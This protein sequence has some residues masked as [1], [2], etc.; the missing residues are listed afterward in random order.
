MGLTMASIKRRDNGKWRARY[1]DH[2]GKEHARHFDKRIDAETWLDAVKSS[3]ITGTYVD[4]R[5]GKVTLQSWFDQWSATKVWAKT[6]MTQAEYAV[7]S[8]PFLNKELRRITHA[9]VQGWVKSQTVP[10]ETRAAGLSPATIETRHKFVSMCFAAA[11]KE[12][13]ISHNPAEGVQLP[14]KRRR[15]A[16]MTVPTPGEVRALLEASDDY[17]R[18]FISVA[19]F[20]GLRLGEVAGL[21][22]G[23]VD[24]LRKTITV[25][26]QVQGESNTDQ[27][28]VPPKDGSERVVFVPEALTVIL[29]QHLSNFGAWHDKDGNQ[30]MFTNGGGLF[31]RKSAAQRFRTIRRRA[32]L[33]EFTLHDL[34]HFFASGLISQGCDVVTVQRALG[35][36]APSVT[37][38][39]YSHLWPSAEDKTRAAAGT[40]MGEVLETAADS[41]R[42]REV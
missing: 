30:W 14:R 33:E 16:A 6:T 5:A 40:I 28:V 17:F 19:A 3:F 32:G 26:R 25:E 7:K 20:A 18:S 2:D 29:S 24:C 8:T 35:H 34:R 1:R 15:A 42:T 12:R 36:S 22:V 41:W 27:Y 4:P 9:E 13:L 39:V 21:R 10:T 31:V 11:V 23:D 38:D 37:L